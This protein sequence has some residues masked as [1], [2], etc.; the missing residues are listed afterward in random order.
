MA[1]D[2]VL[3][4]KVP[5]IVF[6]KNKSLLKKIVTD[7]LNDEVKKQELRVQ[8]RFNEYIHS[9]LRQNDVSM[10]LDESIGLTYFNVGKTREA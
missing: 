5:L 9:M 1:T 8:A 4:R 2:V 3:R 7:E 10:R 6:I